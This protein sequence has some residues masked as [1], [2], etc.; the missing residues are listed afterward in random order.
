[1]TAE[2]EKNLPQMPSYLCS[3]LSFIMPNLSSLEDASY[4]VQILLKL[5]YRYR[6]NR[7]LIYIVIFGKRD[8]C[9]FENV[10]ILV[11]SQWGFFGCTVQECCIAT[12]RKEEE[13]KQSLGTPHDEIPN[14]SPCLGH[15]SYKY[16]RQNIKKLLNK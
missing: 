7:C 6:N 9:I 2:E 14:P 16:R 5:L 8:V 11:A 12:Y 10:M 13:F 15:R 4:H 1:M 3:L